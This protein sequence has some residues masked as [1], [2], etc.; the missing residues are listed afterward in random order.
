M[1]SA[2]TTGPSLRWLIGAL[3]TLAAVAFVGWQ[4]SSILHTKADAAD[5]RALDQS[6]SSHK[7]NHVTKDDLIRL[8][9]KIDRLLIGEGID[10]TTIE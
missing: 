2:P 7:E 4:A 5:L 1:T 8:E 10:P 9:N 3:S 6:F